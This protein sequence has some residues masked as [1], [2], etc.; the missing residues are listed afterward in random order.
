MPYTGI[1]FSAVVN[2]TR[3]IASIQPRNAI[4]VLVIRQLVSAP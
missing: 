4:I 1:N 3:L 2:E